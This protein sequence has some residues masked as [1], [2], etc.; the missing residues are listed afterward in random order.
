MS[1]QKASQNNLE[2]LESYQYPAAHLGHL[3]EGQ[4]GALDAFKELC[5]KAGY[6]KPGGGGNAASHDDETLLSVPKPQR[7]PRPHPPLA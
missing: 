3:T 5:L 2:R 7:Q 1:E 4:Q 6:Y